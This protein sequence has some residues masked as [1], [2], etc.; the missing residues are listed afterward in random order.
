MSGRGNFCSCFLFVSVTPSQCRAL[1][2]LTS[3][4]DTLTGLEKSSPCSPGVKNSQKDRKLGCGHLLCLFVCFNEE[5]NAH[6]VRN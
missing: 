1:R 6:L 5:D 4:V 2:A 3:S